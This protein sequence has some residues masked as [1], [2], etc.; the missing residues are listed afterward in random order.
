[1]ESSLP[2]LPVGLLRGDIAHLGGEQVDDG[3][4]P[5]EPSMPW[6]RQMCS[7]VL[8]ARLMRVDRVDKTTFVEL[9]HQARIVEVLGLMAL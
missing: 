9:G 1:M 6:D 4:R 8:G 2:Y 7:A 3:R 5:E